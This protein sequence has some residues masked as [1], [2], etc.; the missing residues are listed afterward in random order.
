[1]DLSNA[2]LLIYQP[3]VDKWDGNQIEI[4]TAVAIKPTGAQVETFG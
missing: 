2:A 3:Q 4:H 1:M